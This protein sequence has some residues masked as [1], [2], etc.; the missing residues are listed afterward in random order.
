MKKKDVKTQVLEFVKGAV[1]VQK[2]KGL[3]KL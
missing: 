1:E 3:K 2:K